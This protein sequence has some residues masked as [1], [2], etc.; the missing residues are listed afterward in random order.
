VATFCTLTILLTFA[1]YLLPLPREA[2]PFV[3]VLIPAIIAISLAAITEGI[4]GVRSLLSKLTQWRISLKWLAIALAV[5]LAMRLTIS[6][7]ERG[8]GYCGHRESVNAG[9]CKPK[10]GL[11]SGCRRRCSAGAPQTADAYVGRANERQLILATI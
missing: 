7:M 2:L 9:L 5:A 11:I 6:R 1:T 4:P 8:S 3:M 10:A